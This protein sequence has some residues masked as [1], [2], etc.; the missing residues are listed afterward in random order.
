MYKANSFL[1]NKYLTKNNVNLCFF[2]FFQFVHLQI[3]ECMYGYRP[4]GRS[5]F[6]R[7][8]DVFRMLCGANWMHT[9]Q[10]RTQK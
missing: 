10:D 3:S 8:G 6:G 4:Q 7:W 1:R 9:A 5:Y 2:F